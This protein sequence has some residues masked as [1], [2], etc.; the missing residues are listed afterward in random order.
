MNSNGSFSKVNSLKLKG[1]ACCVCEG[2]QLTAL[3]RVMS[4]HRPRSEHLG[5]VG[6]AESSAKESKGLQERGAERSK[7]VS[8]IIVTEV[9]QI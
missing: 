8:D 9:R 4:F 6:R 1:S 5:A 2:F 3:S 7:R